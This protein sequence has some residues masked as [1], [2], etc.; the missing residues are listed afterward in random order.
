MRYVASGQSL[1]SRAYCIPSRTITIIVQS[2]YGSLKLLG[3]YK[4]KVAI[5]V[6]F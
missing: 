3:L 6:G 5:V 2:M 4:G 1:L